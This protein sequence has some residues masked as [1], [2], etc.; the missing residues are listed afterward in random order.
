[1]D[2]TGK[3]RKQDEKQK[4]WEAEEELMMPLQTVGETENATERSF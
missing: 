2:E 1:M 3:N 4:Q